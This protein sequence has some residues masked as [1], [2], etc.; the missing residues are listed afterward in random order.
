MQTFESFIQITNSS[1][2]NQLIS[3]VWL[4]NTRRFSF[5]T[6]IKPLQGPIETIDQPKR[7]LT[8]A[9]Q[10][11]N[12]KGIEQSYSILFPTIFQ[13]ISKITNLHQT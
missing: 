1:I 4:W 2:I 5:Q 10:I 13:N 12:L 3:F 6:Y 9:Y 11:L 8:D 7:P